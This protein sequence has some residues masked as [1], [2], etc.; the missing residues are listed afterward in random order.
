VKNK[1]NV[2]EN[3]LRKLRKNKEKRLNLLE[4][5]EKNYQIDDKDLYLKFEYLF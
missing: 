3:F 1:E 2:K 4:T 5:F